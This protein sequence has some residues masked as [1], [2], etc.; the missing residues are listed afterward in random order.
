MPDVKIK[1]LTYADVKERKYLDFDDRYNILSSYF[2]KHTLDTLFACPGNTDSSRTAIVLAL[3]DNVVVGKTV[4]LGTF[5]KRDRSIVPAETH[6]DF[7]IREEFRKYGI[8]A[9]M[10]FEFSR[11]KG[12]DIKICGNMT[13]M[14]VPMYRK[15]K[16]AVFEVPLF[17]KLLNTK[18]IWE[19]LGLKGNLLKIASTIGNWGLHTLQL[20]Y[21]KRIHNLYRKY[22]VRKESIVPEW[23]GKLAT[24]NRY[25]FMEFH[26]RKWLQWNLDYNI[27]GHEMDTQGFYS[28]YDKNDNPLGF[29][30]IKERFEPKAGKWRNIVRGTIVEWD[31]VDEDKLSELDINLL[32]L[33]KFSKNVFHAAMI[34]QNNTVENQIKKF[35]LRFH[36]NYYVSFYDKS[37]ETKDAEEIDFWRIR[38]GC[39][40]TIIQ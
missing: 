33:S 23:A 20:N 19:Y 22:E 38:Y 29:F 7:E 18:N 9:N 1:P 15:L 11:R 25:R 21:H 14:I 13:G 37:K 39:C 4:T 16:Y 8:G 35:G 31:T 27:S 17:V 32:A 30:M 40:N 36:K 26:D 5:F 34:T 2:T 3:C 12:T 10:L 6:G 28:I 24:D